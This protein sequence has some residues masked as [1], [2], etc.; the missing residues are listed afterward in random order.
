MKLF[1]TKDDNSQINKDKNTFL[2]KYHYD[3]KYKKIV[4]KNLIWV[5]I[6]SEE[7]I[8]KQIRI[9]ILN[10]D[11][12][13]TNNQLLTLSMKE[14]Y[15]KIYSK[16]INYG[17]IFNPYSEKYIKLCEEYISLLPKKVEYNRK[18]KELTGLGSTSHC[19]KL[20]K[21]Y[22]LLLDKRE[23]Y[24]KEGEIVNYLI[25]LGITDD[26]TKGGLPVRSEKLF[27]KIKEQRTK[28]YFCKK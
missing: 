2:N 18:Y 25:S 19:D 5:G 24:I 6:K 23:E 10:D 17:N 4:E 12:R 27:F 8:D 1:T 11:Y 26:N 16:A 9:D 13:D 28:D 3:E 15:N 22:I 21:Q 14:Q 20:L 7:E